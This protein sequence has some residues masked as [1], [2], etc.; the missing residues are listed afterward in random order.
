MCKKLYLGNGCNRRPD[1]CLIKKLET[2]NSVKGLKT[3]ASC[4][5]HNKYPPSIIIK[6]EFGLIYDFFTLKEIPEKKRNRY[7][8]KDNQG[9][10][11]IPELVNG[12]VLK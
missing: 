1:K 11:Y 2:I 8:V 10:Y 5:G 9:Y 6:S 7:Y 12:K 4:C 3:V